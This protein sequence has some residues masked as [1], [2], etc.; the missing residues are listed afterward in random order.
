MVL[1]VN[2]GSDDLEDLKDMVN[3]SARILASIDYYH[4]GIFVTR[5]DV[6]SI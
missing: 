3:E 4:V 2:S 5:S 6:L 1:L